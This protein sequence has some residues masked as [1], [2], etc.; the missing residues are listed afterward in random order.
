ML[1]VYYDGFVAVI[2]FPGDVPV[3]EKQAHQLNTDTSLGLLS[4]LYH[5]GTNLKRQAVIALQTENMG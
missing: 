4:K 2:H 1:P 5:E 3:W